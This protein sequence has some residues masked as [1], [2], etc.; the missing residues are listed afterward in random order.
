MST[1]AGS[2][3]SR[4]ARR[5]V[6]SGMP[7]ASV[8]RTRLVSPSTGS[9]V[10]AP[11]RWV[12]W[13][14]SAHGDVAEALPLA[15]EVVPA[16]VAELDDL[17]VDD[18]DLR[19]VRGVDDDL[20]AVGH[21]RLDL[22]E[23][24]RAG[25]EVGVARGHQ[26]QHPAHRPVEVPDVGLRGDVG[27]RRP[28]RLGGTERQR[29]QARPVRLGHDRQRQALA[30]HHR[31][32]LVDEGPH[33]RD[34]PGADDLGAR[35]ERTQPVGQVDHLGPGHARGT[36]TCCRPRSRPPRGAARGRR[37]TRRRGRPPRGSPA[38]RHR[39]R[40]AHRTA[41]GRGRRRSSRRSRTSA[42]SHHAWFTTV[43]PGSG[44]RRRRRGARRARRRPS[45]G[46]CRA[47]RGR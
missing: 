33:R 42:G 29:V 17:G 1:S 13:A 12:E 45:A 36:G 41:R 2:R 20:T 35:E 18:G 4:F 26:R 30:R 11:R 5:T 22:V 47:R 10:P 25:P 7:V 31:R 14:R 15:D 8:T 43:T 6:A 44:R 39:C 37:S 21:D 46:G 16:V 28:G 3:K 38:R 32:R 27:R 40:A 23:A 34:R 24:L 19:D 9:H